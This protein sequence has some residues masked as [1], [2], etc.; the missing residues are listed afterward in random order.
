MTTTHVPDASAAALKLV[1]SRERLKQVLSGRNLNR[2]LNQMSQGTSQ[3]P[4]GSTPLDGFSVVKHAVRAWWVS[5]PLHLVTTLAGSAAHSAMAPIAQRHPV[6]LL[7]VSAA[8]GCFIVYAR[9]WRLLKGTGLVGMWLPK[10]AGK[11]AMWAAAAG[12]RNV[13]SAQSKHRF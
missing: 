5:H 2:P 13:S 1:S 11:A 4:D 3:D 6:R 10:L 9:P 7:A 8:V 12:T